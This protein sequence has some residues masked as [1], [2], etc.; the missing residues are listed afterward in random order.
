MAVAALLSLLTWSLLLSVV[1]VATAKKETV[2]FNVR[3]NIPDH[4]EISSGGVACQFFWSATGGTNEDWIAEIDTVRGAT[5]CSFGR[6]ERSSYLF[7]TTFK[8]SVTG[9]GPVITGDVFD[10]NGALLRDAAYVLQGST[11]AAGP[12]WSGGVIRRVELRA[13][14]A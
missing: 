14:G 1:A 12:R 11:L 6:P 13:S 2:Q 3:P 8:A 9:G 7:F 4:V 5:Q 10:N